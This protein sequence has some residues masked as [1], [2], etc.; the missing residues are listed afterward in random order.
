[1]RVVVT[2]CAGFI[3]SKV[4]ELMLTAGHVVTGLDNL[5]DAY[6]PRL[7][8][9][10]L[11][12]LLGQPDFEFQEV[13][14]RD[15]EGLRKALEGPGSEGKRPFDVVVNLAARAGVRQS[16]LDP[17][18]YMTTNIVG[19]LNLLEYCRKSG[20]KK[21]ILASS[22]SLYGDGARP[23][24]EDQPTDRPLS[25][26]AASKKAAEVLCHS[27]HYL[28]N[29]DITV[30]RF[31]TVYGPAG[32][33][34]MSI[35]RFIKWITDGEPVTLFGD[36]SQERDFTFIDDIGR[37]VIAAM[38]LEGF[39]VINL[40][41]DFPASL[42][43]VIGALEQLLEKKA[44]IVQRPTDPTDVPATWADISRAR[45]LLGWEPRVTLDEGLRLTV[46]WYLKS[47]AWASGI[48]LE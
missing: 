47:H 10:R 44:K 46:D 28:H 29:L 37:G 12:Q 9:W 5:N 24:K 43:S 23:F 18:S 7:K 20:V 42:N 8:R 31:F 15:Q 45:S 30:L 2:G 19:T 14:I 26:Y 16:V 3:G 27:Y 4:T 21:Y 35:F 41:N 17:W 1:M 34:D 39:H 33:P 36:G 25:P 13:D 40:G 11:E 38:T 6:D 32:R 48:V 22:S